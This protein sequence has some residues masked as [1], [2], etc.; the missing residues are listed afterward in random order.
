MSEEDESDVEDESKGFIGGGGQGG[1]E[2]L[3]LKDHRNIYNIKM[4]FIEI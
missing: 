4:G 1:D 3:G 2:A